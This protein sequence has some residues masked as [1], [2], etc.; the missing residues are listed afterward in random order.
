MVSYRTRKYLRGTPSD[1]RNRTE[2][3]AEIAGK[4]CFF[5]FFPNGSCKFRC[6]LTT[7]EYFV[8]SL[9]VLSPISRQECSLLFSSGTRS[10]QVSGFYTEKQEMRDRT[11]HSLEIYSDRYILTPKLQNAEH[12]GVIEIYHSTISSP[13]PEKKKPFEPQL[14]TV[15]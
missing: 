8:L 13:Q 6:L 3:S 5:V 9:S 10:V 4:V 1:G 12:L 2:Q 14:M 15:F 7:V 11:G